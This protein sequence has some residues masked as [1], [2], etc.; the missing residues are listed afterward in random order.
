M[1]KR[2]FALLVVVTALA[3]WSGCSPTEG[4]T[5]GSTNTTV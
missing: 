3:L 5:G 2:L 1:K 4:P